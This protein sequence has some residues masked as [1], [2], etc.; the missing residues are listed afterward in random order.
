M[1]KPIILPLAHAHGI[2]IICQRWTYMCHKLSYENFLLS[3]IFIRLSHNQVQNTFYKHGIK[4]WSCGFIMAYCIAGCVTASHNYAQWTTRLWTRHFHLTLV[5]WVV[6][7]MTESLKMVSIHVIVLQV[8]VY[9]KTTLTVTFSSLNFVNSYKKSHYD[10]LCR[11]SL[12]AWL[13]IY[14]CCFS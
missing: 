9:C 8:Q 2:K 4:I 6:Y 12:L 7:L 5:T 13:V 3:S 10:Q 14:H 1:D 11:E